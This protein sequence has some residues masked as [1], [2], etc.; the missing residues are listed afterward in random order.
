[1]KADSF[2]IVQKAGN[3][4]AGKGLQALTLTNL[5]MGMD[6]T[7]DDLYPEITNDEELL[8]MMLKKLEEETADM[9]GTFANSVEPPDTELILLFKR[10]YFLF[11]QRPYYLPLIFDSVQT[12]Y[13]EI[14][15][16]YL[17][18]VQKMAGEYL[19]SLINE[20][21]KEKVFNS[22]VSTEYLVSRILHSFR[23]LMQNEDIGN[24]MIRQL[25]V[26]RTVK[27]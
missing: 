14:K 15:N 21:K 23:F 26:L 25:N 17:M 27:D 4:I 8:E 9:I 16:R 6:I 22:D 24:D 19:S 12:N 3:L 7:V 1:M 13:R 20:G 2:K 18:R 11:L 5:L 10:L